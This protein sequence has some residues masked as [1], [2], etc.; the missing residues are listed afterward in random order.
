MDNVR[1][2][3]DTRQV[4]IRESR[5]DLRTDSR[6][7]EVIRLAAEI[8]GVTITEFILGEAYPAAE[9]VVAEDQGPLHIDLDSDAWAAFCERLDS[10]P[11]P[12]E[13]LRE[14]MSRPEVF[15]DA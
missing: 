13:S 5:I 4:K 7:K 14:L 8:R 15:K 10:P 9:R 12:P 3:D 1:I 11:S 2:L 6:R